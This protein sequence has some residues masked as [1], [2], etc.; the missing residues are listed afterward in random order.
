MSHYTVC[1]YFV[2]TR[3]RHVT[4]AEKLHDNDQVVS[5]LSPEKA[6]DDHGAGRSDAEVY[7]SYGG[8][9]DDCC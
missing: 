4:D 6:T 8:Q 5:W 1:Y 9:N 3:T 2:A 7:S